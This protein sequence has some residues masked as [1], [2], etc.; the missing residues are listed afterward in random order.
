MNARRGL[1]C[2]ILTCYI[3]T[4]T[5]LYAQ[6][7][8]FPTHVDIAPATESILTPLSLEPEEPETPLFWAIFLNILPGFGVGSFLQNNIT[9]GVLQL[10]VDGVPFAYCMYRTV[11]IMRDWHPALYITFPFIT[12]YP[13][14]ADVW[15]LF[16]MMAGHVFGVVSAVCT[17]RNAKPGNTKAEQLSC[18]LLPRGF[19]VS[20]K[21]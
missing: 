17:H 18:T 2:F 12:L 8:G 20:Y 3:V 7:F 5:T 1:V 15:P 10:I 19:K 14:V 4:G 13:L 9:S 21:F 16:T 11:G 6:E